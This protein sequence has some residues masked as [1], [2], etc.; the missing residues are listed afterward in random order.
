VTGFL[1]NHI[2]YLVFKRLKVKILHH[3]F[4]H[5]AQMANLPIL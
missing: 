5:F 4:W 2:Q 3:G 1:G